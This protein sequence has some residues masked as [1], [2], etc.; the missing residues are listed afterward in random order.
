MVYYDVLGKQNK[1]LA[2]ILYFCDKQLTLRMSERLEKHFNVLSSAKSLQSSTLLGLKLVSAANMMC[3]FE[4]QTTL[5]R[6]VV[7]NLFWSVAHFEESQILV[8]QFLAVANYFRVPWPTLI[9]S[10]M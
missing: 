10:V 7:L 9:T 5:A 6:P 1:V 3:S 8:A 2:D 4:F